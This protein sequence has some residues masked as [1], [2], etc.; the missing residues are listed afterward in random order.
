MIWIILPEN[1]EILGHFSLNIRQIP[2]KNEQ[3]HNYVWMHTSL[4]SITVS[5]FIDVL[6]EFDKYVQNQNKYK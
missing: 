3:N 1:F 6:A 5:V 4:A 2:S